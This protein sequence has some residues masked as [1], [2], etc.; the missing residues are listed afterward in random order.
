[1][2]I[3]AMVR[4]SF[5]GL[6]I[7]TFPHSTAEG[8]WLPAAWDFRVFIQFCHRIM[9]AII[10]VGIL[11]YGHFLFWERNAAPFLRGLGV[12]LVALVCLQ[13][14]LGAQIIWTG[15]SVYMTTGHVVVGALTLAV[16]FVVTFAL[17]RGKIEAALPS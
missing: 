1:L 15:R 6:A 2:S 11:A 14:T 10:G 3:A 5:A 12:L 13:I 4:H 9:A 17:H 16:T 7:P 8:A